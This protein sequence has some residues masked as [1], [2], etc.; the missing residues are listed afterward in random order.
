MDEA[1]I[2]F[3]TGSTLSFAL[4]MF[5]YFRIVLRRGTKRVARR[6][7][8]L[9]DP[10]NRYF[11]DFLRAEAMSRVN[12]NLASVMA[13]QG[14]VGLGHPQRG[15]EHGIAAR[16]ADS[17]QTLQSLFSSEVVAAYDKVVAAIDGRH[18]SATDAIRLVTDFKGKMADYLE[19]RAGLAGQPVTSG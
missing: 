3:L 16:L 19:N 5:V 7:D 11:L 15:L 18:V 2:V 9:P 17:R 10:A 14:T 13:Q 6:A 4:M 1:W 12:E 8:A